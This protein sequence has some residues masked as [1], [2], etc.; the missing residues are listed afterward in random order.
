MEEDTLS[1]LE[2]HAVM[3]KAKGGAS[4][5][6]LCNIKITEQQVK[7]MESNKEFA[8]TGN[9]DSSYCRTPWILKVMVG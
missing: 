6:F 1:M 5:V 9:C 8:R 3:V 2:D 4:L 7:L